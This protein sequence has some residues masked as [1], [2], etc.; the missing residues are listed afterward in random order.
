MRRS[1]LAPAFGAALFGLLA[2]SAAD[3]TAPTLEPRVVVHAV[4]DPQNAEQVVLVEM[5]RVEESERAERLSVQD[6]VASA[7]GHPVSGARVVLYGIGGDSVV[8]VEDRTARTDSSGAGMYRFRTVA[9]A[10]ASERAPDGELRLMPGALY[11]L[12]VRTPLGVVR[13][14][15]RLPRAESAPDREPRVFNL[16]TDTLRLAHEARRTGAGAFFLRRAMLGFGREDRVE[17]S[18]DDR[19]LMPA[20]SGSDDEWAFR[21]FRD[22][23]LPGTTQTFSVVAVDSNYLRYT[24]IGADPFGDDVR[25]NTLRGG[26]GL[27]GSVAVLT[28][29]TL[30][31]VANREHAIE[32]DWV[33]LA[34]APGYPVSLRLY[35]SP[36]Y[37]RPAPAPSL[38]ASGLALTGTARF[39]NGVRMFTE[40][41]M[42]GHML[43]LRLRV[44]TNGTVSAYTAT[45]DGAVLTL[46]RA[47]SDV[48]V[49]YGQK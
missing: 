14:E 23:I 24:V 2:C 30:E 9:V 49:R 34:N 46:Q 12:E 25:G 42:R 6:L 20:S 47:G 19:L 1:V 5:T 38:A 17:R 29:V 7:G 13:G 40:A 18:I 45:F 31:L 8:A 28:D 27:F 36:R 43:D 37:R 16:D 32:G 41:E 44:S 10:S 3:A 22:D 15:T 48:R 33:P 4:L 21:A 11:R 26:V 35:E 39:S